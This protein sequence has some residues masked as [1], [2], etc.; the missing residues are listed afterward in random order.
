MH[1]G[2]PYETNDLL[3]NSKV[4]FESVDFRGQFF[5]EPITIL[6]RQT[7]AVHELCL[8]NERN[9]GDEQARNQRDANGSLTAQ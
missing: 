3:E 4:C 6:R 8:Q 2:W 1:D 7:R 9:E 5:V